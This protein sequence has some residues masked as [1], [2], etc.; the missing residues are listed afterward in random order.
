MILN[1]FDKDSMMHHDNLLMIEEIA[2]QK[3]IATLSAGS[4]KLDLR[5]LNM[6]EYFDE[7]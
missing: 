3:V 6:D 7:C 2:R 1:N 5:D 4:T